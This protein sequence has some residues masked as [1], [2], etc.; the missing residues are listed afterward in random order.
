MAFSESGMLRLVDFL[1]NYTR[2]IVHP[3][4]LLE[5]FR[6]ARE[7]FDITPL[8]PSI[9]E[10]SL[11]K[12]IV[13]VNAAEDQ[14]DLSIGLRISARQN[15]MTIVGTVVSFEDENVVLEDVSVLKKHT[16]WTIRKTDIDYLIQENV[17]RDDWPTLYRE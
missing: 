3:L 1:L 17:L 6:K 5:F 10:N 4:L 13:P 8:Y 16:S 9:L 12:V 2:Q 7:F 15:G 14:S 11:R